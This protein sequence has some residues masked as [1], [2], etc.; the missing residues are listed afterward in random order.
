[1]R[2]E[3]A[4]VRRKTV[5]GITLLLLLIGMLT[6]AFNIQPVK[7]EPTTW[8]VDKDGPAD[9]TSI[10]EAINAASDGDTIFVKES[11]YYEHVVVNKSVS[12]IGEN[13]YKTIIY[14]GGSG[15]VIWV[16]VPRGDTVG[17]SEIVGF[18]I[19][20]GGYGIYL[21]IAWCNI[22][23]N[24]IKDN[25]Y[26]IYTDLSGGHNISYNI[27]RNN[28]HGIIGY[29]LHS[30]ISNND[31]FSNTVGGIALIDWSSGNTISG[32]D[33]SNNGDGITLLST[34]PNTLRNNN[35]HNN[36]YNFG[37]TRYFS[38]W[39][40]WRYDIDT[41]NTVDGKPIYWWVN[42]TNKEIPSDAG[43]VGVVH[44]KNITVKDLDLSKNGEGVF[45][46]NTNNS[47]ITNVSISNN[48]DGIR[49]LY[50]HNNTIFHNN[51]IN[52]RNQVY[53]DVH[54]HDSYDNVWDDGYPSG[55]NYWSAYTGLDLYRGLH[56]N[57]TGCDGIGDTPYNVHHNKQDHYP[58]M[59][60]YA[61][62]HDIGIRL[63]IS[64]IAVAEG[65]NATVSINL[66]IINYGEQTE[67]SNFTF[68]INTTI[69]EQTLT[70]TSRNSTTITFTWN[71]TGLPRG[72]YTILS[73]NVTPVPGE[74]D[75]T[76]NTCACW[77]LVTIVGDVDGN[78]RVDVVDQRLVQLGMFTM[79]G[80]PN[81]NSNADVDG[82]GRVDVTDQRKQQLHMFESW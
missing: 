28:G 79:P 59:K 51:F 5:S 38:L 27:V 30:T 64:K 24:I 82:N 73:A 32:N 3:G 42:Q 13:K 58:L 34:F 15:T 39:P 65:Y 11:I 36:T 53:A 62:P 49:L 46:V 70:L 1:M 40:P 18:T 19:Q 61:G 8:T 20:Y 25:G 37:V 44:S 57:E 77:I 22:S 66:T 56:Q 2:G 43:Y 26:G 6:L 45:F 21:D 35:I 54:V 71:I 48:Y 41:S 52:N 76:D 33:V 75:T 69:Q 50:S 9:F 63:S 10:Q 68:Q 74:T 31:I 81:W 29:L 78:R 17:R 80:Y 55:G 23:H 4:V 60:P 47:I 14:G 72:N 7:S 12:L 16:E 67:N